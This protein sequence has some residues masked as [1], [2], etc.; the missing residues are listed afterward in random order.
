M[1][2]AWI[3]VAFAVRTL[4]AFRV[5]LLPDETYYWD[6]TRHLQSGYYD[7]PPGIALLI[8]TGTMMFGNTVLGVRAGPAICALVMHISLTILAVRMGSAR[9]GVRAAII[10]T[11]LPLATLGLVLATPDAPLLASASVALLC[12]ERALNAPVNT[13]PENPPRMV[14]LM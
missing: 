4:I 13:R 11:L 1:S 9:D 7:H 3:V 2:A 10:M 5:P 6:W 14:P 8:R 12:V